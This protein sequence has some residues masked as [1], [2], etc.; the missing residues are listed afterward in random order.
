MTAII[1]AGGK[2]TRM[3]GQDKAF[4]E[5]KGKALV[6]ILIEKLT[7]LA[8]DIIVVTNSPRKYKNL[9]V[10]LVKDA[11]AGKGPLMGM[12]S[13]LKASSSGY[14]FITACDTPFVNESLIRFMMQ[15]A[16]GWDIMIPVA[17]YKFHPLCGVY[18]KKCISV[19][20]ETL[21][22]GKLHIS[23]IFPKLKVRFIPEKE[24]ADFD[25]RFLSFMNINTMEDLIKAKEIQEDL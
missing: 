4:L 24:I 2:N 13:G 5:I 23:D 10:K 15:N 18:S 7:H 6:E 19:M 1:L 9:N 16:C 20:E 21:E 14:N 8:E 25:K 22:Q 11:S 17:G 12:C 3:A